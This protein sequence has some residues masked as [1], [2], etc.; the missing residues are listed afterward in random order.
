MTS[1]HIK[2]TSEEAELLSKLASDA[3][4]RREFIDPKMPGHKSDPASIRL[5]KHLVERLQSMADQA[6]GVR[7]TARKNAPTVKPSATT[8]AA[9]AAAAASAE[10]QTS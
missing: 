7:P 6:K 3:L 2:L 4:F 8:T 5:G 1:I 10:I 9:A